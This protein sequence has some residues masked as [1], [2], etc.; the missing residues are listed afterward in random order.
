MRS[1]SWCS[2]KTDGMRLSMQ[3]NGVLKWK[4]PLGAF[5]KHMLVEERHLCFSSRRLVEIQCSCMAMS[6]PV[7][8]MM[9]EKVFSKKFL[10]TK[11]GKYRPF[12]FL[13]WLHTLVFIYVWGALEH[14]FYNQ[15]RCSKFGQLKHFFMYSPFTFHSNLGRIRD[16][17]Y[18]KC[19]IDSSHY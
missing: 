8:A 3:I 14:I 19:L 1:A 15:K 11:D 6:T 4:E 17:S 12:L 10:S 5:E 16:I 18:K 13:S 9:S 2:E 7:G